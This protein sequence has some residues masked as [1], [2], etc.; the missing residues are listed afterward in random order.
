MDQSK[1]ARGSKSVPIKKYYDPTC[2]RCPRLAG[3]LDQVRAK[4]P[5]YECRPVSQFGLWNS[6]LLIV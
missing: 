4:H 2:V 3:F 1:V 5:T 6:P